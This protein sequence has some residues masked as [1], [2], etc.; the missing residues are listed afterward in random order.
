MEMENV[1]EMYCWRTDTP[2]IDVETDNMVSGYLKMIDNILH[3]VD[4]GYI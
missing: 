3:K 4:E 1:N 2:T